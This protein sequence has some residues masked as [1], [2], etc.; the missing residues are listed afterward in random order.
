[1]IFFVAILGFEFRPLHL[2]GRHSTA[3]ATPPALSVLV[4]LEIDSCFLP[5]LTWTSSF[6]LYT[7]AGMTGTQHWACFFHLAN[8]FP[9]M[10]CS[11][12]SPNVSFLHSLG[13]QEWASMPS[14]YFY[15]T[16]KNWDRVLLTL[17]LSWPGTVILPIS[18]FRVASTGMKHWDLALHDI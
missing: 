8:F 11:H 5:R 6:K 14:W 12:N 9:E 17:C 16:V 18:A 13:W 3:W 1:M 4:I 2:P 7:I 15:I 10:T